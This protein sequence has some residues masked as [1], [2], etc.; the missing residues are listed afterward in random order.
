MSLFTKNKKKHLLLS[1]CFTKIITITKFYQK[2]KN[3]KF[4]G[5]ALAEILEIL[6]FSAD[7][8]M[9]DAVLFS[10]EEQ[11]IFETSFKEKMRK[12]LS[13]Q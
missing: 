10:E 8:H 3:M 9:R 13:P 6:V 11:K 4:F 7:A 12:F 1:N 2:T 5:E